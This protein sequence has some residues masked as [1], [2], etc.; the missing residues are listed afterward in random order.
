MTPNLAT[1]LLAR[2]ADDRRLLPWWIAVAVLVRVT[3]VF[4]SHNLPPLRSELQ[5]VAVT[6]AETGS[7]ANAY[8]FGSGPTT[9]VGPISALLPASVY[10]LFGVETHLSEILLTII[11]AI[12]IALTA[13]IYNAVFRRL[14][15]AA[16]L[17]GLS[18]LAVVAF[19]SEIYLEAVDL[20]A[21]ESGLAALMLA[22][23]ML[24]AFRSDGRGRVTWRETVALAALAGLLFLLSPSAALGAYAICGVLAVRRI[25][26][27]RWPATLA[28]AA[29][30]A[31]GLSLPWA[32]RNQRV[33]GEMIWTRANFGLE[34][35]IGTNADAV[36]PRDPQASFLATLK[37]IHPFQSD[38]AYDRMIAAGG[39]IAYPK[40]LQA[41][42]D[43]WVARHPRD[44]VMVWLRHWREYYLPPAWLW[45]PYFP[46]IGRLTQIKAIG[47]TLTTLAAFATLAINLY[48]RRWL[49][50]YLCLPLIAV[51]LPYIVTQPRTRYR[52]ILATMIIFLAADFVSTILSRRKRLPG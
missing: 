6:L 52:Y 46:L 15:T 45:N 16:W 27:A 47:V 48:R 20:R 28:I 8:R 36:S 2:I 39:E 1:R 32:L 38:A 4:V 35:A 42:T 10:R 29:T 3:W 9:H 41:E 24:L 26:F 37:R 43:A 21:R 7:I 51:S 25:P 34:Y 33:F 5:R 30:F 14:A 40:K 17:R 31:V 44:A 19:P 13:L 11:S 23:I 49:Y 50:F 22:A 12:V 18:L